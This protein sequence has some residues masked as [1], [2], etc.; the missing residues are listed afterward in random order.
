M[1]SKTR[2]RDRRS[3]RG[4]ESDTDTESRNTIV[5]A[6]I[7]TDTSQPTSTARSDLDDRFE[8]LSTNLQNDL[9]VGMTRNQD[10]LSANFL[11]GMSQMR[12]LVAE[13]LRANPRNE[14]DN[15]SIA[16]Q[17]DRN[18]S[19]VTT[20]QNS[21][22]DTSRRDNV[23]E[24]PVAV[25]TQQPA[26]SD[27]HMVT[28]ARDNNSRANNRQN[29]MNLAANQSREGSQMN[30]NASTAT[31]TRGA[32]EEHG[33]TDS[34]RDLVNQIRSMADQTPSGRR[35]DALKPFTA[36]PPTFDGK[37]KFEHFEDLF[38][39]Y[40]KMLPEDWDDEMRIYY[41]HTLLRDEALQTF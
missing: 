8:R 26:A 31:T 35:S 6:S 32:D 21:M 39:T 17:S 27:Y 15:E 30:L 41:F 23:L 3:Q 19:R 20:R 34:V 14:S 4:E 11:E 12:N 7:N 13:S 9:Q 38:K 36:T 25:S 1:V 40:L 22:N 18:D 2:K 16:S 10:M 37:K 28:G 24:N 29:M 5:P 33:G